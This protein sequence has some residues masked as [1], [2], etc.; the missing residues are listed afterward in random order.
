MAEQCFYCTKEVDDNQL[1]F[2][3]FLSSMSEREETLCDECYQ[4]WLQGIK[5]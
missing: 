3:T 2:V 1:H 5:E 4:E